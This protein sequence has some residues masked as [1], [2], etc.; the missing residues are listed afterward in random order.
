MRSRPLVDRVLPDP[1]PDTGPR[2]SKAGP[3]DL[4]CVAFALVAL[5]S[6]AAAPA[7]AADVPDLSPLQMAAACAP[8]PTTAPPPAGALRIAG[9]HAP[10]PHA[11]FGRSD[12][13]VIDGGSDR[14]VAVDARYF[15]RRAISFGSAGSLVPGASASAPR[16][17]HTA[18]WVRVVAVNDRTAIAAVEH[19]CGAI[20][21]GD[22]LESF[23]APAL[24]PGADRDDTS[25][26]PDFSVRSRLLFGDMDKL[27]GGPGD[28]MMIDRGAGAGVTPGTRFAV[29]RDINPEAPGLYPAAAQP[30]PLA[31]IGELIAVS[32]GPEMT[33]VRITAARDALR[34]GDLAVQ[35]K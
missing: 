19:A 12:L 25:A 11:Q 14:G 34:R 26:A 7:R 32:V 3:R 28:F 10:E 8:P 16:P 5:L 2:D 35:R 33:V 1:A 9:A 29:Y 18:G 13:V 23:A 17:I 6:L 24:P 4:P 20:E 21:Q 30:L 22:F 27:T 15:V 31:P